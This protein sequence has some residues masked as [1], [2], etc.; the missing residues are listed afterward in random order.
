MALARQLA[1][2][3]ELFIQT[4]GQLQRGVLLAVESLQ[5]A[6][7]AEGDRA[8]RRGLSILP[9]PLAEIGPF[10]GIEDWALSN[11]GRWVAVAVKGGEIGIWDVQTGKEQN[12]LMV[13]GRTTSLSFDATD[14]ILA[15]TGPDQPVELWAWTNR[16]PTRLHG[17]DHPGGS[18]AIAFHPSGNRLSVSG[19]DGSIAV[20]AVDGA[21]IDERSRW[22]GVA[23]EDTHPQQLTWEEPA[24]HHRIVISPDGDYLAT[25]TPRSSTVAY[26]TEEGVTGLVLPFGRVPQLWNRRDKKEVPL[27]PTPSMRAISSPHL[28]YS[29]VSFSSDDRWLAVG[30]LASEGNAPRA[31]IWEV[32]SGRFREDLR[33]TH[34]VFAVAF[35]PSSAWL[36]TGMEVSGGDSKTGILSIWDWKAGRRLNEVFFD[37]TI[38]D[39]RFDSSG[40][41][42]L[43]RTG[44]T[45]RHDSSHQFDP[46]SELIRTLSMG[47]EVAILRA[48][49]GGVPSSHRARLYYPRFSVDGQ[50]LKVRSLRDVSVTADADKD[51]PVWALEFT[52]GLPHRVAGPSV[53]WKRV[54]PGAGIS[55]RT[56]NASKKGGAVTLIISEPGLP[57]SVLVHNGYE[58]LGEMRIS[59]NGD[60]LLVRTWQ[61][62]NAEDPDEEEAESAYWLW[63]L[64]TGRLVQRF[65]CDHDDEGFDC[66]F[67][68]SPHRKWLAVVNDIGDL[69]LWDLTRDLLLFE[70]EK[71]YDW[72]AIDPEGTRLWADHPYYG[73][74]SMSL[75]HPP[76]A[77][78]VF[79]PARKASR[80]R[81]LMVAAATSSDG[82]LVALGQ[83]DGVLQVRHAASGRLVRTIRHDQGLTSV[84]FS[85]DGT[86]LATAAGEKSSAVQVFNI[87]GGDAIAGIDLP[88]RARF[89]ELSP[90]NRMIA[91]AGDNQVQVISLSP[92]RLIADACD[93]L[94]R[95]LTL[96]EWSRF[97]P[98]EPRRETCPGLVEKKPYEQR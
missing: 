84:T 95:A 35:R 12:R 96:A 25:E 81:H 78:A 2:Q 77:V 71:A 98:T 54:E 8:L 20:L 80:R 93:R 60:H 52:S 22:H 76:L 36:L 50:S 64:P 11:D 14:Q 65:P 40:R 59:P 63:R 21:K 41:I 31:S 17:I 97:L 3:A 44:D 58:T 57:P 38:S 24:P 39:L 82:D 56:V 43:V 90:D 94:S 45:F 7:T 72:A 26:D 30:T 79:D 89:I 42:L 37:Q 91:A 27:A 18:R 53:S 70:K 61:Y 32:E 73:E 23:R 47:G 62:E 85:A 28:S 6:P 87:S 55:G 51:I 34:D 75:R 33:H 74:F 4:P 83:N 92:D 48:G 16:P 13:E 66:S 49:E 46:E 15:T 69:Q 9:R 67:S 1:A 86:L 10:N 68:F 88:F 19:S 29:S 5:R